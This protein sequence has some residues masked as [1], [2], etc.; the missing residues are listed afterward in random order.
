MTVDV[1]VLVVNYNTADTV[2]DCLRS[3]LKQRDITYE[4]IAV[5]NASDDDSV[6]TL[7][8]FGNEINLIANEDNL[9]FGKANNQ[10][11]QR[12]TGDYIFLLNPD[13]VLED[14]KSLHDLVQFT[15]QNPQYGIVGANLLDLA[16]NET[17]PRY[18]YP[19]QRHA[20]LRIAD[21]PGE[22]AWLLGASL[23]IRRDL[24][25]EIGGFDED[26]FLYGEEV[27]LCLRARKKGYALGYAEAVSVK[28]MGGASERRTPSYQLWCKKQRGLHLFY[29]KH[30]SQDDATYLVQRD[31]TRSGLRLKLLR[32][33]GILVGLSE[34][35]QNKAHRYQA[36]Y[37]TS[38]AFLTV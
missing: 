17:L 20:D 9:G 5:D 24:Y 27:D 4:I 8:A 26:Y 15:H 2:V 35:A 13:A 10:A 22:I 30:Y 16:G 11:F 33:K 19:G 12:S 14:D 32:L 6:S 36:I 29:Q 3:V 25:Q 38:K 37:D 21:L 1:S 23:M 34:E 31:L 18:H 7:Q 28:H